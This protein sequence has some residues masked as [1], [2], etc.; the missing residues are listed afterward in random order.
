MNTNISKI[1]LPVNPKLSFKV[2]VPK[3]MKRSLIISG[4]SC[5]K[6]KSEESLIH[7]R[8]RNILKMK[9]NEIKESYYTQ[10]QKK[11]NS[12]RNPKYEMASL[13]SSI[14]NS[15]SLNKKIS[16]VNKK[17]L[18][19]ERKIK[20]SSSNTNLVSHFASNLNTPNEG[21]HEKNFTTHNTPPIKEIVNFS[22]YNSERSENKQ[23]CITE[24]RKQKILKLNSMKLNSHNLKSKYMLVGKHKEK[25]SQIK[26]IEEDENK[27]KSF[28]ASYHNLIRRINCSKEEE[29]RK[30]KY[31]IK[32]LTK[33]EGEM[34]FNYEAL[35]KEYDLLLS[36]FKHSEKVRKKQE[37]IIQMLKSQLISN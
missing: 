18:E 6:H 33:K 31:K 20:I 21:I 29:I 13:D 12:S 22:E 35:K 26:E 5:D 3:Y 9:E 8:Q 1:K 15:D 16:L 17:I 36:S 11:D 19:L 32:D 2:T 34:F 25:P 37:D 30:L 10:N 28:D 14:S 23:N 7:N 4:N 27:Y 24:L